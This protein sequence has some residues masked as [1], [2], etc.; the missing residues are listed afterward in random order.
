MEF[1]GI[2]EQVNAID[3]GNIKSGRRGRRYEV[4]FECF[5]NCVNRPLYSIKW[6]PGNAL[7]VFNGSIIVNDNAFTHAE[8]NFPRECYVTYWDTHPSSRIRR[9]GNLHGLGGAK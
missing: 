1:G 2:F 5:S 8:D 9:N 4:Y 3:R 7:H 6:R